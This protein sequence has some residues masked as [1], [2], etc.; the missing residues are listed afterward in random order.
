MT[1]MQKVQARRKKQGGFT[2]IE[3]MIVVAIIAVLAA[4]A[5]PEFMTAADKAKGAKESADVMTI[6]N[7]AQLYMF[8][9]GNQT[10]PTVDTLVREGY[11]SEKV[12]TPTGGEYT[13]SYRQAEGSTVKKIYV[14]AATAA[15]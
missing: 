10:V 2:L 15:E 3:L 9:K 1:I 13:I 7:A 4:I 6:K 11:L 14:E 8:D 12:K 5:M